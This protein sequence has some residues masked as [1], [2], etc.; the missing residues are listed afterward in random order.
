MTADFKPIRLKKC[1]DPSVIR[2]KKCNGGSSI[3]SKKCNPIGG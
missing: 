2:L 3:R 1:N